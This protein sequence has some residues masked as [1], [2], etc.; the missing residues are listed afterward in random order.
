[1]VKL[2][3]FLA[4]IIRSKDERAFGY[5]IVGSSIMPRLLIDIEGWWH[6]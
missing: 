5:V 2:K 1:M 3:L 4:M 6:K